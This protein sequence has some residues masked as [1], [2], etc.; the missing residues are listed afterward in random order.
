MKNEEPTPGLLWSICSLKCPRCRRGTM[1]TEKNPYKK[2]SVNYMLRMPERC[3][4]CNQKFDLE[5]GFWYG[6]GFVSYGITVF[7]SFISFL[8]WWLIV[9]ISLQDN[10]VFYWIIFN[11]IL[12]IA[13]QPWLMRLSRV[14]YIYFFVKY[15][16]HY[17]ENEPH[18]FQ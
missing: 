6:T 17:L 10:R 11:A 18:R 15:D 5:P 1:F 4:V 3:S 14:V 13:L 8:L 2:L 16:T 9:G 12:I 7:L